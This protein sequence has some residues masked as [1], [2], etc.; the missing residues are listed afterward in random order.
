MTNFLPYQAPQESH[1]VF[2]YPEDSVIVIPRPPNHEILHVNTIKIA[3]AEHCSLKHESLCIFGIFLGS[4]DRPMYLL[5][6]TVPEKAAE[7]AML[8]FSFNPILEAK[9]VEKDLTAR[10]MVFSELKH[11]FERGYLLPKP[12]GKIKEKI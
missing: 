8:R 5:T 10:S 6:D 4:L 9:V 3:V 1:R 7:L 11:S 12:K 2:F